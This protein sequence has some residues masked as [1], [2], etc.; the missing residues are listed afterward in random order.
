[1]NPRDPTRVRFCTTTKDTVFVL[2]LVIVQPLKY[3]FFL[4]CVCVCVCVCV[5]CRCFFFLYV[6]QRP[7]KKNVKEGPGEARASKNP[8]ALDNLCGVDVDQSSKSL[9]SIE[10]KNSWR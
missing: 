10:E 4:V 1:M 6:N 8:C 7:R 5:F 9:S 2:V 3:S